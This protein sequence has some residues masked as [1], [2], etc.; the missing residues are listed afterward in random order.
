MI[1]VT[2]GAGFIG[3]VLVWK[4]NE[5]G[6][7]DILIVD[8]EA[9]NS[10]KW[11]NIKKRSF[12]DYLDSAP[13]LEAVEGGKLKDKIEAVFHMGACSSTTEMN[14]EYLRENNS[15]YSERLASWCLENNVYFQYASSA[16]TYGDGEMGFSD[17]DLFS[18]KLHPLNPYGESKLDFDLWLLNNKLQSEVV[19]FRFFNVYGPNEYH[20]DHMRSVVHKGFEQVQST[21]KLKLFKSYRPEYSDGG[22]KRDFIYVKDVVEAMVWFYKNQNKKGIYNLGRGEAQTWND[23]AHALFKACGKKEDIE[24]IE[25]PKN[26]REQYQYFTEADLAKLKAS[27]C[28]APFKNLE[29]GV[30]DYVREH[31]LKSDPYL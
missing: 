31:L 14:R 4:L 24:Y 17:N 15:Y 30:G 2:G 22:Q 7:R 16:A 11:N 29:A 1:V 19:G 10:S 9:K 13:F 23:L 25:M 5:I 21:G 8:Q 18:Y 26:L 3:S 27:G 6:V 28:P 12:H 20:K